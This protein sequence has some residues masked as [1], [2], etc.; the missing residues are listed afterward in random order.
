VAAL[1][2]VEANGLHGNFYGIPDFGSYVTWR[3]GDRGKSYVDTRGFFFPP[4]LLEDSYY[5]PQL[6]PQWRDR[7]DRVLAYGTD[8]FLLETSGS[9]GHLWQ[10][11][12]PHIDQP[13]YCDDRTVVLSTEQVR[14]ALGQMDQPSQ[15]LAAK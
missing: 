11:L 1:D 9:R 10:A 5:L 15:T 13:L 3:L 2:W 14:H 4:E 12:K 8:Y 7:L 6:G